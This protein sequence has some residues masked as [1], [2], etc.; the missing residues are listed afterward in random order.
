MDI[1]ANKEQWQRLEAVIAYSRMT[2]H[3]FAKH[4]GLP[5]GE[6]LYRIKRGQNG[7]SRDV[8][9]RIAQKYPEIS[10]G[11]LLCGEGTMLLDQ[12]LQ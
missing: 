3:K 6:N 11:W 9:S 4:I 10:I 12:S 1:A 8:A 2:T 7:I 5:C